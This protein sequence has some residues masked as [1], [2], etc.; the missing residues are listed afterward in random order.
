MARGKHDDDR[1]REQGLDLHV[2]DTDRRS[3]NTDIDTPVPQGGHLF[4]RREPLQLHFHFREALAE[5]PAGLRNA[6]EESCGLRLV[7][8]EYGGALLNAG[9]VP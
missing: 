1:L 8:V 2:D 9:I 7:E 4:R 5:D 3:R 6:S